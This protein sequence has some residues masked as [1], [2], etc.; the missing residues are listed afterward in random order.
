[1]IFQ[2]SFHKNNLHLSLKLSFHGCFQETKDKEGWR[3][4]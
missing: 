4:K 2:S 3:E 1:M